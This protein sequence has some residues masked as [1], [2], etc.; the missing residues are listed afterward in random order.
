MTEDKILDYEGVMQRLDNDV[1]LY[2]EIV[3]LFF[4][5]LQVSLGSLREAALASDSIGFSSSAHCMKGALGNIGAMRAYQMAFQLEQA[6]KLGNVATATAL[7]DKL[8]N[9]IAAFKEA[10]SK[11]KAG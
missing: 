11:L 2:H 1:E 3:A 9:E 8:E 10:Y 6:G 5:G 4:E 7:V